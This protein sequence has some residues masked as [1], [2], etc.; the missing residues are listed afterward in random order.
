M[1]TLALLI[2]LVAVASLACT[3]TKYVYQQ[4]TASPTPRNAAQQASLTSTVSAPSPA[5]CPTLVACPTSTACPADTACPACPEVAACPQCPV[6]PTCPEPVV[7]P[8]PITCPQDT[9]CPS[10]PVCPTPTPICNENGLCLSG[11][12]WMTSETQCLALVNKC[13]TDW[14][15]TINAL[16]Q[17]NAYFSQCNAALSACLR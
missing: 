5:A 8:P 14:Q 3:T 7:C 17:C 1:K 10:A 15:D 12:E 2:A 9:P 11:Q 13:T 6:C 16:N 4:P